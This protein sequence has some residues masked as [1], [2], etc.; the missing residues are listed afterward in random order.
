MFPHNFLK[1]IFAPVICHFYHILI[2]HVYLC[3]FM[4]FLVYSSGL[5]VELTSSTLF[6]DLAAPAQLGGHL[7]AAC[8]MLT[9]HVPGLPPTSALRPSVSS[10]GCP[11]TAPLNPCTQPI[12]DTAHQYLYSFL[13]TWTVCSYLHPGGLP[14]ACSGTVDQLCFP[15]DY[16]PAD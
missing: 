16:N 1:F 9:L 10:P 8:S 11:L 2:F 4:D 12:M 13:C 15:R 5:F 6:T 3:V 7:P 14:P